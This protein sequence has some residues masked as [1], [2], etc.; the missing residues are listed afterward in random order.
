MF[1]VP[2]LGTIAYLPNNLKHEIERILFTSSTAAWANGPHLNE[3][4]KSHELLDMAAKKMS[5]DVSYL[6][7][8][9]IINCVC[10]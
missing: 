9:S 2:F 7:I 1:D 8:S 10:F 4:Y 6:F 5:D 3:E